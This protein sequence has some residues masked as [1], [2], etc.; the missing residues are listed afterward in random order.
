MLR[1]LRFFSHTIRDRFFQPFE[2][3]AWNNFFH[4]AI[5]F[6]TQP[7]LQLDRFSVRKRFQLTSRYRDMRSE[8]GAEILSMWFNLGNS[9]TLGL[10]YIF[11]RERFIL[12]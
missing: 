8:M 12:S 2:H 6:M 1:A 4:C 5:A 3:Q 9:C 10:E 11:G 7:A